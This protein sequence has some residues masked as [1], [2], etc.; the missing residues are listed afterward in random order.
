M[1]RKSALQLP[2]TMARTQTQA[3]T[4]EWAM[5]CAHLFALD[6]RRPAG[7]VAG[8]LGAAA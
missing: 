4:C 7:D 3:E 8:E 2:P 1:A 6:E 5:A